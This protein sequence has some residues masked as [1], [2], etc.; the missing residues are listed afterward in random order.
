MVMVSSKARK[1]RRLDAAPA[2]PQL[3]GSLTAEP[4]KQLADQKKTVANLRRQVSQMMAVNSLLKSIPKAI[5]PKEERFKQGAS[6]NLRFA[7][8]GHGYYDAFV[9]QAQSMVLASQVGPCT[10]IEAHCR[11]TIPGR[12]ALDLNKQ[13]NIPGLGPGND[14]NTAVMLNLPAQDYSTLIVFNPG[15]SDS[16]VGTIL[17]LDTTGTYMVVKSTPLH[18]A[19]FVELG[20]SITNLETDSDTVKHDPQTYNYDPAGRIENIPV[21]GSLRIRNITENYSV[22][23][24]VRFLRYNGGL[25][26]GGE[27]WDGTKYIKTEAMG[28]TEFMGLCDMIRDSARTR[29]L[30]GAELRAAHQLNTYPADAIRSL[31]FKEDTSFYDSVRTPKFNTLLIL[32]DNFVAGTGANNSYSINA[33]VQRAARFRPGSL[34]HN[35]ARTPHSDSNKH[36][37]NIKHA[38]G[39]LLKNVAVGVTQGG[40]S[41]GLHGAARHFLKDKAP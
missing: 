6:T 13:Y 31:E 15:S 27:T 5:L 19:A 39:E 34:L 38:A 40:L 22:G 20:P 10:A 26:L 41:G 14:Q 11:A 33:V 37:E 18:A 2:R 1:G 24:E 9:Q 8:R 29:V 35:A 21:R 28:V 25:A 17:T 3:R 12:T 23:G 30:D 32:I 4:Q 16:Q 36:T 7:A